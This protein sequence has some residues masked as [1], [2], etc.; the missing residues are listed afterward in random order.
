MKI[1]G[2]TPN[3]APQLQ[4]RIER[5]LDQ[6]HCPQFECQSTTYRA[7]R[8]PV[9]NYFT[10]TLQCTECGAAPIGSLAKGAVFNFAAL[11]QWDPHIIT[12][13]ERGREQ[14]AKWRQATYDQA[15]EAQ[16]QDYHHWLRTSPEWRRLRARVLKR[17]NYTCESCLDAEARDVHHETY[18]LGRLPPAMYLYAVCRPCHDLLHGK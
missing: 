17:A 5:F 11:S 6:E 8:R 14:R 2:I 9:S 18:A 10:F 15:R 16:R 1:V 7:V 4:D 13:W 12:D 3:C